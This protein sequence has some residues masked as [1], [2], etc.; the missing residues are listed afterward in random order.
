MDT[1][2]AYQVFL[3]SE[4]VYVEKFKRQIIKGKREK[5]VENVMRVVGA[6]Y[7]NPASFRSLM[8]VTFYTHKTTTSFLEAPGQIWIV[9]VRDENSNL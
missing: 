3:L 4:L 7:L 9:C 8:K 6:Y 2:E 5:M 1:N